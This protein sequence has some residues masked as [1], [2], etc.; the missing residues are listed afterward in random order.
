MLNECNVH[1]RFIPLLVRYRTP[2][3]CQFCG[4]LWRYQRCTLQI[5]QWQHYEGLKGGK[6]RVGSTNSWPSK[7]EMSVAEICE[8]IFLLSKVTVE[9]KVFIVHIYQATKSFKKMREKFSAEYSKILVIL[10]IIVCGQVKISVNIAILL[11]IPKNR[12]AG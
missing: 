1:M 12:G 9:Q 3:S 11:C 8:K 10:T 5:V 6:H 7:L 4:S 2:D